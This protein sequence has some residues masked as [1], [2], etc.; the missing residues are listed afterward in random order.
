MKYDFQYSTELTDKSYVNELNDWLNKINR[1]SFDFVEAETEE[2]E[3]DHIEFEKWW[4]QFIDLK[5]MIRE[6]CDE[7]NRIC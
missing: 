2:D 6:R 5:Q 7:L 1:Q 3:T 4:E